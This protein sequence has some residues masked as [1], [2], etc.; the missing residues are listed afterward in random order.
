MRTALMISLLL[1]L[2]R[3][4]SASDEL[5]EAFRVAL[6]FIQGTVRLADDEETM[7]FLCGLER[8]EL[9]TVRADR[10]R[11]LADVIVYVHRFPKGL[12]F[13]R[14]RP[15]AVLEF[16]TGKP[17]PR[18]AALMVGQEVRMQFDKKEVHAHN[19]ICFRQSHRPGADMHFADDML[20]THRFSDPEPSML[21]HCGVHKAEAV[22]LG[23]FDHPAFAVTG[24]NG[25]FV[26]PYKLPPGDYVVRVKHWMLKGQE[27]T[28]T[29]AKDGT[30]TVD[31][32]MRPRKE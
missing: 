1:S 32:T 25:A 26:L 28:V 15:P 3:E 9:D 18:A 13:E 24:R 7:D 8:W 11:R 23:V 29:V 17:Q 31:F 22:L 16:K 20:W 2:G 6:G 19:V 10:E 27:R 4:A 12:P 21:W 14:N 30:A 5:K